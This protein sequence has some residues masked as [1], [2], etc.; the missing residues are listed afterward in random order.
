M[1][2]DLTKEISIGDKPILNL[3]L[4]TISWVLPD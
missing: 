2:N 4:N 3:D 1:E